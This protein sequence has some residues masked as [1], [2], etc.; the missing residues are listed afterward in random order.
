MCS[1]SNYDKT[2]L[3]LFH[4]WQA[5]LL[6]RSGLASECIGVVVHRYQGV[7]VDTDKRTMQYFVDIN[8]I[9]KL[10]FV[11]VPDIVKS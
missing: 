11:S 8:A 3:I 10:T 2:T 5:I 4:G 7:K 6:L 9:Q 1:T